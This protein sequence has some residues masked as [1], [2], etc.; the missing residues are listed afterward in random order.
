MKVA[1]LVKECRWT[2][3]IYNQAI[4]IT[5]S[6]RCNQ[7]VSLLIIQSSVFDLSSLSLNRWLTLFSLINPKRKGLLNGFLF[8]A[9]MMLLIVLLHSDKNG[10]VC[11]EYL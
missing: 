3:L 5:P 8:L 2:G 10:R 6:T 9:R 4:E 7:N 11:V 1:C